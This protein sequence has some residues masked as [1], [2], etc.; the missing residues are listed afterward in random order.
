MCSAPARPE[1]IVLVAQPGA[2]PALAS[3]PTPSATSSRETAHLWDEVVG[4]HIWFAALAAGG[5]WASNAVG[6]GTVV[7]SLLVAMA[8]CAFGW[9][10]RRQLGVVLLVGYLPAVLV[11]GVRLAIDASA[12]A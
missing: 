11:L 2:V 12:Q 3:P 7:F 8:A 1:L 9:T 4:H 10:Q 6:G 5:T